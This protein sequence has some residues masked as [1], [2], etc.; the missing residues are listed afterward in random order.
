MDDPRLRR[1]AGELDRRGGRGEIEHAVR[2][3]E[4]RQRI[5]GDR[6]LDRSEAG[7]LADIAAEI[8]GARA[9]DGADDARARYG[10]DRAYQRLPHAAGRSDHDKAHIA[11]CFA[12][13][14]AT[15]TFC[16]AA[17]SSTSPRPLR[18]WSRW[19]RA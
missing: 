14:F 11:H 9:L 18:L 15:A 17:V 2:P 4:D 8:V 16:V 1:I 6:H 3:G 10:V 5:I 12:L 19:K 7:D 13:L